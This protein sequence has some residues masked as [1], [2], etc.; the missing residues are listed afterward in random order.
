MTIA[1]VLLTIIALGVIGNRLV[2]FGKKSEKLDQA[3]GVLD[4]IGKINTM[5]KEEEKKVDEVIKKG[6]VADADNPVANSFPRVQS[7]HIRR[8]GARNV[9]NL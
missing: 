3:E 6:I 8:R 4:A 7:P 1:L 5:R 2:S 9:S